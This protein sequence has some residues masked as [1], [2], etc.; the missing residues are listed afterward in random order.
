ME[1][2]KREWLKTE[3]NLQKEEYEKKIAE[4][5]GKRFEEKLDLTQFYTKKIELLE[6]E[7][8]TSCQIRDILEKN[9]TKLKGEIE[10]LA[11]IIRTSRNHFKEL[12]T[13]NFDALDAQ[14]KRYES[15]IAE[16]KLSESKVE[17]LMATKAKKKA[18]DTQ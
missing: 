1:R 5:I 3:I 18:V 17:E 8:K 7:L 14:V 10:T 2:K 12:E 13:S 4:I 16:L 15:K 9:T 6:A 11:K